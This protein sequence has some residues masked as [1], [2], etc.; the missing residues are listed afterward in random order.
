MPVL[1]TD[2]MVLYVST[3]VDCYSHDDEDLMASVSGKTGF[4]PGAQIYHD[5]YN[6][7]Q[8]EPVFKLE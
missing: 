4:R 7:E 6:L 3:T 1:T 8:T 5:S 2:I